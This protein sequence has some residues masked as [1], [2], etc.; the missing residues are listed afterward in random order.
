MDLIPLEG[1]RD[2]A[3]LVDAEDRPTIAPGTV[4]PRAAWLGMGRLIDAKYFRSHDNQ[5]E[6]EDWFQRELADA[7]GRVY[8]I[9]SCWGTTV[10]SRHHLDD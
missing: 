9:E 3:L 8:S 4:S 2:P 1:A 6:L 7:Q 10:I 5:C